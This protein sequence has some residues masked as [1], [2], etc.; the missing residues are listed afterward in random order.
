MSNILDFLAIREDIRNQVLGVFKTTN[1][2]I[3]G[4]SFETN[5]SLDLSFSYTEKYKQAK[6]YRGPYSMEPAESFL[7]DYLKGFGTNGID[8][9]FISF[10]NKLVVTGISI[11]VYSRDISE[12]EI[13]NKKQQLMGMEKPIEVL[14]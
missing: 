14:T 1:D 13:E 9:N 4:L 10:E 6:L 5:M 2:M 11:R 12:E 7:N 3:K 8:I